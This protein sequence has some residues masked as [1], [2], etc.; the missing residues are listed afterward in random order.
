MPS[1]TPTAIARGESEPGVVRVDVHLE[2][3]L[4]ADDEERISEWL[5]H[6]LQ[7]R[8]VE[9]LPLDDEYRAIAIGRELQMDRV[10]AQSLARDGSIRNLL[11]GH[12]ERETARDLHEPRG[13]CV[14]DTRVAEDVEHLGRALHRVLPA[15]EHRGE[16]LRR[17]EA[18]VLLPLPLL[19]HLA[20]DG[21]HRSLDRT[22]DGPV[23]G[24]ARTPERAAQARSAHVV[25][26][27]EHVDESAHDLREDHAGVPPSAHQR[28]TRDLLRD[29]LAPLGARRVERL[30]DRTQR[31]NEIRARVAVG[32]RI[33]VEVVDPLSVRFEVLERSPGDLAHDLEL[34]RP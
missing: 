11:A 31:Q 13:A 20:N 5:E 34:H 15:G 2:R 4:V 28:R 14:D 10:E 22:L 1:T 16:E 18:P 21:E 30:D 9:A 26:A 6:A 3:S 23:R 17:R 24:I 29:R 32:H 27:A 33:D 19:G 7:G 8:L 25:G 12:A